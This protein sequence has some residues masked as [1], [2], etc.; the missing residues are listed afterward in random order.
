[1]LT[2][3]LKQRLNNSHN[4]M[5]RSFLSCI[6]VIALINGCAS[7]EVLEPRPGFVPTG[8]DFS[9]NWILR[10][11][12]RVDDKRIQQ[13]IRRTDGVEDSDIFSSRNTKTG[14]GSPSK[15]ERIKGGLVFV[16][17]VTGSSLKITQ[18]QHGLFISFDRAVV[19]EFRFGEDRMINVGEVEGQRVTGWEEDQLVVETLDRNSMKLTERFQLL[20]NG[21]VVQ[22]TISLRSRSGDTDSFVQLFDRVT[23]NLR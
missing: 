23:P 10:N 19:E 20:H 21:A 1:M 3:F 9:G 18:T 22:R 8:V 17:L 4:Q 5:C 16:F 12:K 2:I 6:F 11:D 7:P 14:T 15:T 13:A